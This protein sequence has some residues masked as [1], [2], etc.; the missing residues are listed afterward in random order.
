MVPSQH[1]PVASQSATDSPH[2]GIEQQ[3]SAEAAV[4]LFLKAFEDLDWNRFRHFIADD[5]TT[6]FPSPE[7]PRRH[8]GRAAVET[9]FREVFD[10]I[11]ADSEADKPPFHSILVEGLRVDVPAENV[12]VAT[13]MI[14]QNDEAMARR[15]LILRRDAGVWR[16]IHLHASNTGS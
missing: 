14:G 3:R 4:L 2:G 7:P 9:V 15:T 5:V 10:A 1:S 13:F 12:A 8:D 16:I 6:F 11:R